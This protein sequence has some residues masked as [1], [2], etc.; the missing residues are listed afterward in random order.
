[1]AV[2]LFRFPNK[3]YRAEVIRDYMAEHGY[4]RAVCFSCGNA[5]RALK[6]AGIPTLDISAGGDLI[7]NRWFEIGEVHKYFPDY[8][9]ATSGHLPMDCMLKI[10]QFY[11]LML[12]TIPKEIILPTGSGETLVCLK[13]AFPET[14]ITAIYNLDAATQYDA[15]APLNKLVEILAAKIIKNR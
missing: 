1:M 6:E 4:E 8:F 15:E 13:L 5:S 10:A 7:A 11:A 2:E 14:K 3:K 9:D 12:T